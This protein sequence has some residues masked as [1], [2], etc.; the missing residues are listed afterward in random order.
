MKHYSLFFFLLFFFLFFSFWGQTKNLNPLAPKEK[1][2]EILT[3]QKF[4]EKFNELKTDPPHLK[5]FI[6]EFPAF[7]RM[8]LFQFF[9]NQ[10]QEKIGENTLENEKS[11]IDIFIQSLEE[12]DQNHYLHHLQ[13]IQFRD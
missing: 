4:L 1:L 3:F 7:S 2:Q 8:L 5:S 12:K 10:L 13:K 6:Q 9:S 11:M